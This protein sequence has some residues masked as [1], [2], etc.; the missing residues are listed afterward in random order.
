MEPT[1]SNRT[2][3]VGDILAFAFFDSLTLRNDVIGSS[4]W[5]Q[6]VI[7][8]EK[9]RVSFFGVLGFDLTGRVPF[10][11]HAADV[12]ASPTPTTDERS[13]EIVPTLKARSKKF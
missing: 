1:F 4:H 7:N 6:T 10:E 11:R 3:F 8:F 9:E 2:S 5:P 12:D 13:A